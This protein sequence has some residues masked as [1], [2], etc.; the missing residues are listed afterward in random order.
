[1]D[2][3]C[4]TSWIKFDPRTRTPRTSVNHV[5]VHDGFTLADL[6]SYERKHNEANGEGNR[7]GNDD[8][9]SWN[10]GVEG[11]TDDPDVLALRARQSRALLSTLL[12]S[13]GVPLLLGGDELGRTQQ[14]NNNAYCQDN[15]VV[16]F[17]WSTVDNDLLDFTRRLIT[18]RR[19]HPVFR[20]RRFLS[21]AAASALAWYTPAGTHDV[22]GLGRSQRPCLTI[23]LTAPATPTAPRTA[24]RRSTTTSSSP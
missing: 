22:L 18:L 9:R 23:H 21:G 20:R 5:A 12:L 1:M 4:G 17:E 7:D 3:F 15:E 16:W 8:N 24:R 10:C 14:G 19:A 13:F 6:V 2:L 11:P